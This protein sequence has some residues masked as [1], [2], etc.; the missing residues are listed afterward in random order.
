M[1]NKLSLII[2]S[3]SLIAY[4]ATT[5]Q[6]V[7]NANP[8]DLNDY[9]AIMG[10]GSDISNGDDITALTLNQKFTMVKT[11]LD[12]IVNNL[13]AQIAELQQQLANAP[14][15]CTNPAN[16]DEVDC[17]SIPNPVLVTQCSDLST[18]TDFNGNSV[19]TYQESSCYINGDMSALGGCFVSNDELN[20]LSSCPDTSTDKKCDTPTLPTINFADYSHETYNFHPL[21]TYVA[22]YHPTIPT[23]TA[24]TNLAVDQH[25]GRILN[26]KT[27]LR[28]A[29][30]SVGGTG[31]GQTLI[32]YSSFVGVYFRN[33]EC[34]LMLNAYNDSGLYSTPLSV[35]AT[36][37]RIAN[38][39]VCEAI[40]LDLGTTQTGTSIYYGEPITYYW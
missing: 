9:E 1:K 16:I 12:D 17:Q 4:A 14:I 38:A 39:S 33:N 20:C 30:Y 24:V 3:I 22:N 27:P 2:L 5:N 25:D 26:Q 35:D 10:T 29:P 40:A 15:D 32:P 37:Q 23:K 11:K 6:Q 18:S 36:G 31:S 8:L 21:E 13:Q 34:W 28:N 19:Q 7:D